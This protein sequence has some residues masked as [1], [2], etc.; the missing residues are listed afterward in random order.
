MKDNLL[1]VE[2]CVV[3][4]GGASLSF[5]A[6][7]NQYLCEMTDAVPLAALFGSERMC[8]LSFP[9]FDRDATLHSQQ[10]KFTDFSADPIF[11]R[12]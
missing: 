12:D 5:E 7:S 9:R 11:R 8:T 2:H 10:I 3:V 6:H 4:P 1:E